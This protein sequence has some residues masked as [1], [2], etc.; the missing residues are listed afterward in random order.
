VTE[1]LPREEYIEQ[2][3]L[4]SSLANRLDSNDPVQLLLKYAKAEV[5]ATTKLPMAIDFLLAELNHTGSIAAAMA[6]ME[7]YF[8]PFQTFL[9]LQSETERG[10]MDIFKAT[11]LLASEAQFR[12]DQA[13]PVGLFFFQFEILCRNRLSYDQG[14]VAMAGDPVYDATWRQW[15]FEV[16]HK[17]GI[18]DLSDLVY[19]HSE[20]YVNALAR[21]GESPVEGHP[22]LFGE[23]EG[24]IALA[25]RRKEPL[26]FFAALQRH[27]NYPAVPRPEP[28]KQIDLLPNLVKQ[29]ERL[30]ARI[31]LLEEEQRE[32]GID[33]SQFMP[34]PDP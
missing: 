17:L 13:S 7:H 11:R 24:R 32:Q 18:V 12:A 14:L 34:K 2:A 20:D 23:K 26:Y 21:K 31:K 22:I 29:V 1:Q 15:F 16:R 25:N 6:R 27:L 33:L 30:E 10:R 5:L 4:F 28:R 3:Y 9:M 8:A 19:V